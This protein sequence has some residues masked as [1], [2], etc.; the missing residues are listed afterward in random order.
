MRTSSLGLHVRWKGSGLFC[1]LADGGSWGVAVFFFLALSGELTGS[2]AFFL[3]R[4]GGGSGSGRASSSSCEGLSGFF[5]FFFFFL[6]CYLARTG[7]L[8]KE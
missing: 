3:L 5:F 6:G 4:S 7:V 1:C 8:R 2:D